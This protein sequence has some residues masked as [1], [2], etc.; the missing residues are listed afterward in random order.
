[1]YAKA[2]LRKSLLAKMLEELLDTRVMVKQSM[3]TAK[4]DR[5]R[6]YF[7]FFDDI[8]TVMN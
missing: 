3:K 5:V 2:S 6:P 4:N 1:M 8:A 7:S